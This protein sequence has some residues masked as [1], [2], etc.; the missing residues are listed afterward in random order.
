MGEKDKK[1]QEEDTEGQD[2]RLAEDEDDTEG[3]RRRL[4]ADESEDDTEGHGGRKH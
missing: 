4:A 2:K 1:S 3:Q